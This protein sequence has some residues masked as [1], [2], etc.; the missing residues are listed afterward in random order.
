MVISPE[1][2]RVSQNYHKCATVCKSE[3]KTTFASKP[4]L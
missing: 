2:L 1:K 4:V 3:K